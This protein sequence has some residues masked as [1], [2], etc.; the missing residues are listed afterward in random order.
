MFGR[1]QG[2]EYDNPV[3]GYMGKQLSSGNCGK[4]KITIFMLLA[5]IHL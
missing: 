4:V 5:S 2:Y 1:K 3:K